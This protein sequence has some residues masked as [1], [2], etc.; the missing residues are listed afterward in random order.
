MKCIKCGIIVSNKK[1][2]TSR[3]Y[4]CEDCKIHEEAIRTLY[5]EAKNTFS[6][7]SKPIE[8]TDIFE[9]LKNTYFIVQRNPKLSVYSTIVKEILEEFAVK[10]R[11]EIDYD[12]LWRRTKSSRNILKILQSMEDADIIKIESPDKIKRIIKPGSILRRFID[13]AYKP[14]R[15]Q[16]QA[17]IRVAAVLTMYVVL[18]EMYVLANART[19]EEILQHFGP[20]TPKAPWVA[21]MFLWTERVRRGNKKEFNE[22]EIRKFFTKRNLSPITISNYIAAL[23]ATS[24][25]SLQQYIEN[26]QPGGS[27]VRFIVREE[28]IRTL[29]RIYGERVREVDRT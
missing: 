29:E 8:R 9:L 15:T 16:E 25:H 26:I 18:H 24:P 2:R 13:E 10:G 11:N 21:T 5:E 6:D 17:K 7:T 27:T 12:E 28:L 4:I 23:K 14:Y 3:D 19:Q 1:V 22:E 20:H